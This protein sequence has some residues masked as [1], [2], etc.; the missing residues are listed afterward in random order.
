MASQ[1][2]QSMDLYAAIRA[3]RRNRLELSAKMA[4]TVRRF[5][6]VFGRHGK[7]RHKEKQSFAF[8]SSRRLERFFNKYRENGGDDDSYKAVK[9]LNVHF[10]TQKHPLYLG[11]SISTSQA[12]KCW[13]LDQYYTRP[14]V[15]QNNP[16]G[17]ILIT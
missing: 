1:L 15:P 7:N 5:S 3:G 12:R 10:Q 2:V 13:T 9:L 6:V 17:V 11:L 16:S 8:A 4:Y 14:V